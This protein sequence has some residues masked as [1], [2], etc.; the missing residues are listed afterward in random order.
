MKE[1]RGWLARLR[2]LN[3]SNAASFDFP[4]ISPG[5]N[6]PPTSEGIIASKPVRY[7]YLA[8]PAIAAPNTSRR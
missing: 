7:R 5:I 4:L 1:I 2:G 6:L 3:E 8:N